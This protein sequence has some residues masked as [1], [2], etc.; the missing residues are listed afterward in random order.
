ML[1]LA[2]YST[3]TNYMPNQTITLFIAYWKVS[4]NSQLKV[5]FQRFPLSGPLSQGYNTNWYS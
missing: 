1:L 3:T 4:W 2:S 5:I